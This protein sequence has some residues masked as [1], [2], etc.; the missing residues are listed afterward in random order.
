M[1]KE[2]RKYDIDKKLIDEVEKIVYK[3]L[4]DGIKLDT[5]ADCNLL[6]EKMA[7]I[8]SILSMIDDYRIA[9]SVE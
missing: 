7:T 1:Y 5:I 2:R 3:D 4:K 8:K 6:N 9:K